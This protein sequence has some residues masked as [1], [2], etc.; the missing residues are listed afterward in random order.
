M[1]LDYEEQMIN[2]M[3]G[4]YIH[5]LSQYLEETKNSR[6]N[7]KVV[8]EKVGEKGQDLADY[9]S[10]VLLSSGIY[11]TLEDVFHNKL[12]QIN[13][14][15]KTFIIINTLLVETFNRE[16][17]S[18]I[19]ENIKSNHMKSDFMIQFLEKARDSIINY[20]GIKKIKEK[21]LSEVEEIEFMLLPGNYYLRPSVKSH[22]K[23]I[24]VQPD[25]ILESNSTLTL[26]EAKRPKGASFQ[27][28]QLAKE[29]V[30]LTKE[31]G[32]KVPLLLLVLG[33]NPPIKV[34][35]QSRKSIKDAILSDLQDIVNKTED[36][37]YNL[38]ELIE[39]IDTSVGW[40]TWKTIMNIVNQQMR[41]ITMDSSSI[42]YS[43]DRLVQS[44]SSSVIRHSIN[45]K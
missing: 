1:E 40:I 25:G 33:D 14:T 21:V 13:Y 26:I 24:A 42:Q 45:D 32:N 43:I 35:G 19:M 30:L 20:E 4:A 22:Q 23:G 7:S 31:C 41:G 9:I 11:K 27:T 2:C 44:L 15:T 3:L 29:F 5:L 10:L 6:N 36:Y 8:Y 38:D 37:P 39:M 12:R 16:Q 28:G 34:E 17:E 18:N